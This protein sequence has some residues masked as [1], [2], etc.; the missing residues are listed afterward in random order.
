VN[1]F[2]AAGLYLNDCDTEFMNAQLIS[3]QQID[4]AE[5]LRLAE[6]FVPLNALTPS[7][8]EY[9]LRNVSVDYYYAGQNLIELG[10]CD[11]RHR[12]LLSGR[13]RLVYPS[14]YAE[15]VTNRDTIYA[16]VNEMP[17]SCDCYADDDCTVLT[18]DSDRL[19]QILSW[20][21]ISAYLLSDLCRERDYD[22]DMAWI[23]TV[24]N[25][26][27]FFKVPPVNAERI[28]DRMT[29]QS[30][31]MGEVILR[32]GEIGA[33]C[34]F[35]KE[36]QAQVTHYEDN[37]T[38]VHLADIGPGRCF[39]ED[40]LVYETLRNATV[41]MTSD[42]VLMRLAKDDFKLLLI[43]PETEE[44]SE[45]ECQ[46]VAGEAVFIDVRS[47]EEYDEGHLVLAANIPLNLMAMKKRLLRTDVLYIFYCDTGR[48]SRAA[49]YL[50][51]KQGYNVLALRGGLMGAGMQYQLIRDSSYILKDGR[52][53]K[54]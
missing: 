14:G 12:Y 9:L 26:N 45:R 31:R 1:Y 51:G 34:Y 27:L 11:Y 33:C 21:Q 47:Q 24:L 7:Y 41:T 42:G 50:L 2:S 38:L 54:G 5:L 23:R 8:L 40:A 46:D 30:V 16:L 36:G 29:P 6:S 32:Q 13:V 25:S 35:I 53:E 49:A 44:I 19:D 39:G 3:Q 10:V 52:I 37:R 43:E 48:R 28:L 15:I 18:I 4:A 20:S 22:E 17:R